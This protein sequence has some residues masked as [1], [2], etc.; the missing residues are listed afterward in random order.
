MASPILLILLGIVIEVNPVPVNAPAAID[1][2]L[3][4]IFIDA[5]EE[6]P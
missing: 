5:N 6:Q 2:T 1:V 4:G 3:V